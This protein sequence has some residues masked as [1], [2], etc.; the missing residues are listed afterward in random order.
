MARAATSSEKRSGALM[1][2]KIYTTEELRRNAEETRAEA[3]RF[4]QPDLRAKMLEIAAEYDR[5]AKRAEEAEEN[6]RIGASLAPALNNW[7]N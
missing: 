6:E 4:T 7:F 1:A 2:A 5:L 3:A